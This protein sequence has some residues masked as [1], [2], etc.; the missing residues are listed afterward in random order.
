MPNILLIKIS[1]KS[2]ITG[3][4]NSPKTYAPKFFKTHG[5]KFGKQP[6]IYKPKIGKNVTFL[7]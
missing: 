6:K 1:Q 3:L 7:A 4:E 2:K 5:Y